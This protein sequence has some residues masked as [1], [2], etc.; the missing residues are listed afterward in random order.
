MSTVL[1]TDLRATPVSYGA[2][3]QQLQQLARRLNSRLQGHFGWLFVGHEPVIEADYRGFHCRVYG[4]NQPWG[5][6]N[7]TTVSCIV[8]LPRRTGWRLTM[9]NVQQV[10]TNFFVN[11]EPAEPRPRTNLPE[12]SLG[13][14]L[15]ADLQAVLQQLP[16]PFALLI[17][18]DRITFTAYSLYQHDFYLRTLD[19]LTEMATELLGLG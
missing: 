11:L 17:N 7:G 18:Y 13:Q 15:P 12:E 14:V 4:M 8:E 9:Q 6:K 19:M 16:L 10:S 5:G 3:N 2:A 1:A